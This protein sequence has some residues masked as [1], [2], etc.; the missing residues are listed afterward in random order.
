LGYYSE[1]KYKVVPTSRETDFG[2]FQ[3]AYRFKVYFDG[4][5]IDNYEMGQ[6][7]LTLSYKPNAITNL[8]LIASAFTTNEAETYDIQGQ[9]WIGQLDNSLG[10][11][12]FGDVVQQQG[13]GT[14]LEHARNRFKATVFSF[15]HKGSRAGEKSFLKWGIKYDH[16]II[17][18]RIREWEMIDSAGY[19]LPHTPDNPGTD[20]PYRPDFTIN[21]FVKGSNSLSINRMSAF[22]SDQWVFDLKNKDNIT[23]TLGVRS[24]F[25]DYNNELLFMPRL[26]LAYKPYKKQNVVF[27]FSTGLYYQPPFYREMR[28]LDGSL[29]PNIKSQKSIHFILGSDYRFQAWN[30]PFIFTTEVYYIYLDKSKK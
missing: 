16:Q 14:F 6:A 18:D 21:Y 22:I 10:S 2:T 29:N 24:Y 19:S 28:N 15:Q 11:D 9:Y 26:N 25:W 1:N 3:Q 13:V 4:N 20:N 30:R 12:E 27:R 7:A 17:D 5:E 23:L 8:K